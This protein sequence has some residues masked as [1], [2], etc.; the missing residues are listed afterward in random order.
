MNILRLDPLSGRWVAIS[1][2]RAHRSQFLPTYD[3]DYDESK[4]PCPFCPGNEEA[5]PPALETYNN[6]GHWL[7]RVVSNRF[8]A[9][10]GN[11]PF[12]LQHHGP[13]FIDAP[14][15]GIHEVLILSPD[16]DTTWADFTP[17]Q[18]GLVME[19]I[20]DR[21]E[22]H[23]TTP[24]LRYSQAIVNSGR[25]AGASVHHPHGQLMG[26]PIIPRELIEEQGNFSRFSGG[27]LLCVAIA[28]EES[29]KDRLIQSTDHT[30]TLAPYWSGSPYE[31]LIL[32]RTHETHLERSDENT[33]AGIGIA[34]RDA[35][36][37]LKSCLGNIA[38]NVVFHSAPYRSTNLFHWHIHILPKLITHAGFE[39]GTGLYINVIPPEEVAENLRQ[40]TCN[41]VKIKQNDEKAA[42]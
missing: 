8:P 9:F 26:I 36:Q 33:L 16:H 18:T 19:A 37:A 7:V 29:A 5:T 15:T 40:Y 22:G 2:D 24:G 12:V 27:C 14:A 34:V 17:I 28:A 1:T 13:V 39:L 20:R 32:P 25:E 30:I 38:Y 21:I 6:D 42:S 3:Q 10:N 4:E 35:L 11:G 41:S 23:R 31:L